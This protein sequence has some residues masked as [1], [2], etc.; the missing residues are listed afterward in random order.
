MILGTVD[1]DQAEH[2][3]ELWRMRDIQAKRSPKDDEFG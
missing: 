1:L 2:E 3:A